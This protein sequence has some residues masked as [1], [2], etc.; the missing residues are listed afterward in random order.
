[1]GWTG[2]M[3]SGGYGLPADQ[4]PW[5]IVLDPDALKQMRRLG[6]TDRDRIS[7][8]IDPLPAGDVRPLKGKPKEWRLR[9][10]DWRVRFARNDAERVIKIFLI[11]PRGAA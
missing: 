8:A 9:V 1:M 4:P 11:A 3:P 7:R 6:R 10:G 5:R 2:K